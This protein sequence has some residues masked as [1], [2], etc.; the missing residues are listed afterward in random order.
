MYNF[1]DFTTNIPKEFVFNNWSFEHISTI[2]IVA[3][4]IIFS[5]RTLKKNP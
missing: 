5:L 1:F 4:C 2:L 3:V